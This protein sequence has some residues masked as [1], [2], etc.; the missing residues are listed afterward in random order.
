MGAVFRGA[1]VVYAPFTG[2]RVGGFV[3]VGVISGYF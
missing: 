3:T 2:T 1:L